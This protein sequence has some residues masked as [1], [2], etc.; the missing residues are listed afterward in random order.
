MR[1]ELQQLEE[2]I[3]RLEAGAAAQIEAY[4]GLKARLAR[5]EAV[6]RR[7]VVRPDRILTFLRPGRLVRVME[8]SVVRAAAEHGSD[9]LPFLPAFA[10]ASILLRSRNAS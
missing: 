10:P 9:L 5:A 7:A 2:Q 4:R 6:V 3:A 8:G 1:E